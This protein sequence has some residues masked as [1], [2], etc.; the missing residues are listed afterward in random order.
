MPAK[1]TAPDGKRGMFNDRKARSATQNLPTWRI[2]I[3]PP[4]PSWY[5]E[6]CFLQLLRAFFHLYAKGNDHEFSKVQRLHDTRPADG[7][8]CE[9]DALALH[10]LRGHEG[11]PLP[12]RCKPTDEHQGWRRTDS[13]RQTQTGPSAG[14][15]H[16][17]VVG[18][19]HVSESVRGVGL[20][21]HG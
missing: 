20:P 17:R 3:P 16:D 10:Q 21:E 8:L 9:G 5:P 2:N 12:Q 13:T 14:P 15:D 19:T 1:D 4:V 11:D 7:F 6:G 18:K